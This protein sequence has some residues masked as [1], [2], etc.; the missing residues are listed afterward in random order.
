MSERDK[1]M[2]RMER[3]R[4]AGLVECV[5]FF[6]PA[7]AYSPEEVFQCLNEVEDA[8]DA[9]RCIRHASWDGNNPVAVTNDD[10]S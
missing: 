7:K 3:D 8:I 4:Q 9:G 1:F 10:R 6:M 5:P 2:A